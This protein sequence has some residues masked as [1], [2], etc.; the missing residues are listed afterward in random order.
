MGCSVRQTGDKGV[1][2]ML[3]VFMFV[4]GIAARV[5][6]EERCNGGSIMGHPP[7]QVPFL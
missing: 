4:W 7:E 3:S 6:Y 1:T 5:Y 2:Y